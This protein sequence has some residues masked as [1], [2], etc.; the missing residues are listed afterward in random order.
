MGNEN[1]IKDAGCLSDVNFSLCFLWYEWSAL[2][3][4]CDGDD[5]EKK[6]KKE[7]TENTMKYMNMINIWMKLSLQ[8]IEVPEPGLD[9]VDGDLLVAEANR[10]FFSRSRFFFAY[11][12]HY[13]VLDLKLITVSENVNACVVTQ[14]SKI[15]RHKSWRHSCV[16]IIV[17]Y[18]TFFLGQA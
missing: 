16:R 9:A 8:G 14:H 12:C 7:Q 3:D 17:T 5:D 1:G 4:A 6:K 10:P 18:T 15:L 13:D 11:F 2:L